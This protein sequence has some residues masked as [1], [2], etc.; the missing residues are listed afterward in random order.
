M[1][2]K[3]VKNGASGIKAQVA[4]REQVTI[5]KILRQ[6]LGIRPKTVLDF[7]EENGMLV[8]RKAEEQDVVAEVMGCLNLDQS[9]DTVLTGLRGEP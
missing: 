1:D 5:P 6:R 4:E 8:A 2:I 9:T 3:Y 7:Q